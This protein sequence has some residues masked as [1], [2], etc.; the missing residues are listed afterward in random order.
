MV[1][2]SP[3][4]GVVVVARSVEDGNMVAPAADVVF[5]FAAVVA[6]GASDTTVVVVVAI[7]GVTSEMIVNAVFVAWLVEVK[8]SDVFDFMAVAVDF[9]EVV[10]LVALA[11]FRSAVVAGEVMNAD[12]V[13][14][15]V[16]AAAFVG[17]N[18]EGV[19][20]L[21]VIVLSAA[22][23]DL[24]GCILVATMIVDVKSAVLCD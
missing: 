4:V 1:L 15:D 17:A 11:V 14:W 7:D 12:A 19:V 9:W 13:F 24:A 2:F 21:V 3:T 8:A 6:C 23:V 20:R 22:V 5:A 18:T 10:V 16:A